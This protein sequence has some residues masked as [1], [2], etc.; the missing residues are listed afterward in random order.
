MT[1]VR[2]TIL[3]ILLLSTNIAQAANDL[4]APPRCLIVYSK[5]LRDVDHANLRV[6]ERYDLFLRYSDKPNV[7]RLTTR[8]NNG[9]GTTVWYPL[10][11]PNGQKILFSSSEPFTMTYSGSPSKA[12]A[13]DESTYPISL[14]QFEWYDSPV[15]GESGL[16]LWTISIYSK[17]LHRLNSDRSGY[18]ELSWSPDSKWIA[19]VVGNT[20]GPNYLYT[21]D[22][23]NNHRYLLSKTQNADEG[24]FNVFWSKDSRNVY[25]NDYHSMPRIGGKSKRAAF[26]IGN[27]IKYSPDG[28]RVAY[29]K[30]Y[31]N[32]F[33]TQIAN[34]KETLVFAQ[35]GSEL[36][37]EWSSDSR[38]LAVVEVKNTVTTDN[39]A[40]KH[41]TVLYL[42]DVNSLGLSTIATLDYNTTDAKW[43]ND[44]MWLFVKVRV[45]GETKEPNPV[46]SWY[47]YDRE[48]LL[49][50]SIADGSV[51]TLKEP[52]EETRGL[53]WFE[54]K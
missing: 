12:V 2:L 5:L 3:V 35:T 18:Q 4:R 41:Q 51:V 20:V 8:Y 9:L 38:M 16:N 17:K 11:A 36:D 10:F 7:D 37:Y 14:G 43:S 45:S 1:S 19:V 29:T 52:N 21:F 50:V 47:R 44:G 6:W 33:I 48:G 40:A 28:K 32:V 39:H 25:Y 30:D 54:I 53:D 13:G 23:A 26:S 49:A 15:Y 24:I 31:S 34:P 42:F 46:T 22:L 27:N